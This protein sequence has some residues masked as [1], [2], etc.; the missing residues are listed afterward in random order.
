MRIHVASNYTKSQ[1]FSIVNHISLYRVGCFVA[2]SAN[3]DN[4]FQ[5]LMY[6]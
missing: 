1:L 3:F 6:P 5:R 2:I 4:P